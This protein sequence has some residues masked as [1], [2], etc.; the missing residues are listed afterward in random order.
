MTDGRTDTRRT[1]KESLLVSLVPDLVVSKLFSQGIGRL[2]QKVVE[3]SF[4]VPN[5]SVHLLP[6]LLPLVA[7]ANHV[8]QLLKT[9]LDTMLGAVPLAVYPLHWRRTQ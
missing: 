6:L 3:S 8:I 2:L 1:W 5:H 7:V 4:I 9:S